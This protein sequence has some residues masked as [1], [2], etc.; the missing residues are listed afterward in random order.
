MSISNYNYENLV[1]EGGGVRGAAYAGC[2]QVLAEK[3]VLHNIKRVAGT[4]AGSITAGLLAVGAGSEGLTE[5]I[6]TVKFGNFIKDFGW[7]FGDIYRLFKRYGLHTG[8][9]FVKKL[10]SYIKQYTQ[11]PNLT[12]AELEALVQKE[13]HKYKSLT[14]AASNITNQC[15]E[16][17]D[18]KHTPNVPIWKAIR[19]SMSIPFVFEPYKVN[20]NYYM[21]GGLG[22][23]YPIDVYDKRDKDNN[24]VYNPKTL[25]FYLESPN[26]MKDPTFKPTPATINSLKSAG[27]AMLNFL[28]TASNAK[29]I[30]FADHKRTVFVN[31]LGIPSTEFDISEKDKNRL[32]AEGRKATEA[33]F[34]KL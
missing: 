10:K 7:I 19:C 24:Q 2:V 17:F 1:F 16:L 28:Y 13:P 32:I 30:D 21:D 29:H 31:D 5:A 11:N 3:R 6:E 33:F 4:S 22:W 25:G 12:F 15:A 8:D 9:P 18:H 26:Q 20:G 23:I 27:S 34:A 14:V